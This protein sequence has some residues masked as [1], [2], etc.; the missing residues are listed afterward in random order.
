MRA[1][2]LAHHSCARPCGRVSLRSRVQDR[3]CGLVAASNF[4]RADS[5]ALS[6]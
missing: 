6:V 3:S 2:E 1:N 4:Y 5:H